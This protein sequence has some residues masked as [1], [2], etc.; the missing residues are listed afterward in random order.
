MGVKHPAISYFANIL[1]ISS[2]GVP[3]WGIEVRTRYRA[4]PETK[5]ETSNL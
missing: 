4:A 5:A 3:T 2:G 1:E